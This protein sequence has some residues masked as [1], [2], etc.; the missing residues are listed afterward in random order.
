MRIVQVV[1]AAEAI[2][3]RVAAEKNEIECR[4]PLTSSREFG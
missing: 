3:F 4:N 2:V 1:H